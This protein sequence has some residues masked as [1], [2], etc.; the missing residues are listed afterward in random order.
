MD[1]TWDIFISH[2]SEDK[3]RFVR[4]LAL[5]LRL[6]G[7]KVWYDEF[8]L[9]PGDSLLQSIDMGLAHSRYGLVV[10][11]RNFFRKSWPKLELGGL[12]A[13]EQQAGKTI[14]PIWFKVKKDYVLDFSPTLADKVAIS[15]NGLDIRNVAEQ[16]LVVVDP[17]LYQKEQLQELIRKSLRKFLGPTRDINEGSTFVRR[18]YSEVTVRLSESNSDVLY[19]VSYFIVT[20]AETQS[21]TL[22]DVWWKKFYN[23]MIKAAPGK[24]CLPSMVTLVFTDVPA[25]FN[26]DW[27]MGV[28]KE[29]DRQS[30]R[31]LII[32]F[33][34]YIGYLRRRI[35]LLEIG[36]LDQ[37]SGQLET[38][39]TIA[40]K[41]ILEA[42][43]FIE[44]QDW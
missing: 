11:S 14:I 4:P 3:E 22:D 8:S 26:V 30:E 29:R 13:K 24:W 7:L 44:C 28:S 18:F 15:T 6:M 43:D 19:P 16:L 2:A 36:K 5:E 33:K 42:K 35:V 20:S 39:I 25:Q 32:D 9:S 17:V 10:L 34:D 1:N 37:G 23:E 41:R 31:I 38:L 12:V 27:A 40:K 21:E